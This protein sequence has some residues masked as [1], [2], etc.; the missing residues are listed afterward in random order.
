MTRPEP[1][2][3]VKLTFTGVETAEDRAAVDAF[4]AALEALNEV[5][6]PLEGSEEID[7]FEH[8]QRLI[9]MSKD[10]GLNWDLSPNDRRAILWALSTIK[11]AHDLLADSWFPE[12][13]QYDVQG[14][15]HVQ[16]ILAGGPAP[17][18]TSCDQDVDL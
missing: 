9:D 13:M 5:V 7:S 8:V 2:E 17:R 14:V 18:E 16:R 11:D 6:M 3:L 4:M 1:E 15:N 10:T 12:E